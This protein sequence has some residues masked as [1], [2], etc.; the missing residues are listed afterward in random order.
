M[1]TPGSTNPMVTDRNLATIFRTCGR[2]DQQGAIA[3]AYIAKNFAGK[4]IA[5]AHDKTP[6]GKGLADETKKALNNLGVTEV[7]YEGVAAGEK[8]FSALVSKAKNAGADL[9]YWG[10]VHTAG[11]LILRQM[12]D[13]GVNAVFMSG[14]GI[15]S[16]EFAAIA[17]P[18]AEGVLMTFAPDPQ[19]RTEAKPIVDKFLARN[20]KPEAYTL[21]SY[22]TM[23]VL[24][25]AIEGANS[26]DPKAVADYMHSGVVFHTIVG[27]IAFDKK[28][29]LTNIPYVMYTW[30]TQPD[31][32]ITYVQND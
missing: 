8:D 22:A 28:G 27:D 4:K 3:G 9:F 15:A 26:V 17:G 16:D 25:Q 18:G 6:Y 14:D 10:G 2:D 1:I 21:Y 29:D 24:K 12:R 7:L 31:G 11:G 23:Q 20:Y 5:I 30:K 19:K 32:H 13:Q